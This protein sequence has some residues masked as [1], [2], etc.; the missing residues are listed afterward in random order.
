MKYAFI[1]MIF[2]TN[3]L[4]CMENVRDE[5]QSSQDDQKNNMTKNFLKKEIKCIEFDSEG[6]HKIIHT[7]ILPMIAEKKQILNSELSTKKTNDSKKRKQDVNHAEEI[8]KM[9]TNWKI[10][11]AKKIKT[12]G[13]VKPKP[14]IKE[15]KSFCHTFR[16][17]VN[18]I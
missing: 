14:K 4:F 17:N 9:C 11:K 13:K 7:I 18:S 2:A 3:T 15:Y 16:C 5:N 8:K 10:K 1:L 6:K 12:K